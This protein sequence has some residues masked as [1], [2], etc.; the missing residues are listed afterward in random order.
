M[1]SYTK[2]RIES[3]DK[4]IRELK[5]HAIMRARAGHG[6]SNSV[7]TE[8]ERVKELELEKEDLINGTDKLSTYRS[9]KRIREIESE[10][11]ELKVLKDASNFLKKKQYDSELAALEKELREE[12]SEVRGR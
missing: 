10:I 12:Q 6:G 5:E 4:E 1:D 11:R 8:L 3:L 2:E 7:M 9:E